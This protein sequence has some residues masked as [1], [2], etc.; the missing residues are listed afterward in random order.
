MGVKLVL[1]TQRKICQAKFKLSLFCFE[2]SGC[3][4]NDFAFTQGAQITV[5]LKFP[6]LHTLN[7]TFIRKLSWKS[8][9]HC[10]VGQRPCS[11]PNLCESLLLAPDNPFPQ[12]HLLRCAHTQPSCSVLRPSIG[13]ETRVCWNSVL[14]K[15]NPFYEISLRAQKFYL[16]GF[17]YPENTDSAEWYSLCSLW[18]FRNMTANRTKRDGPLQKV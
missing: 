7:K 18:C 15:K 3:S 12:T 13:N 5:H 11:K 4:W 17:V 2:S 1:Y 10:A 14:T 6:Y 8:A 9:S 16:A